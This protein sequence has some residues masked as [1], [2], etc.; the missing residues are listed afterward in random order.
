MKWNVN[1]F[2]KIWSKGQSSRDFIETAYRV[3][4]GR[5]AD[6]GGLGFYL[7][8]L[9]RGEMSRDQVVLSLVQSEEFERKTC[10]SP[11]HDFFLDTITVGSSRTFT[12]F[13]KEPPFSK[14]RLNEITNPSKWLNKDWRSFGSDLKVVPMALQSMHR[15]GFEWT[16]TLYGLH[17]LGKM[18][19]TM[20]VL[21]VG[22]G[23]EPIVYWM[24]RHYKNVCATDLFEGEWAK[25]G[26]QE[27]DPDVINQPEK[28]RPFDYPRERLTFLHMDGRELQF[29]D[30]SFDVV[31]SLSSIEHFGGKNEAA[32]AARE[33]GRV[34]KPGGIAVIATEYILQGEW[35]PEF[36]TERD[37]LEY[38]VKPSGL[39][40]VQ[41]ISFDV[42]RIFIERPLKFPSEIYRSPHLSLTDG[43][44]IWTSIILFFEKE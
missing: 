1:Y 22:T 33:M 35:H 8:R 42:P 39:Y 21:G 31:Y 20:G 2:E 37:L 10:A 36:F 13:V 29:A 26:A 3:I 19:S 18:E 41:D 4:L 27:G 7:E 17:A 30:N 14:Y 16:Q 9:D 12:S 34:L 15:K 23:H 5:A 43:N 28:Y 32:R 40:L 11:L 25:E 6:R 24:A 44:I 38:I